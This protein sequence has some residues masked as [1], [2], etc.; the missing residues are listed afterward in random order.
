[1]P[2]SEPLHVPCPHCDALNR[3]P[4]ERLGQAPGCGRCHR[5][6][7]AAQPLA[8]DGARFEL[9]AGRGDIPLL[10]DFWAPWCGPCRT[11]APHFAAAAPQLEP[12]LRLAKVDTEAEPALGRRF[13]I[14]SIP[15][16]VLLRQGR[17]LARQAGSM[18]GAEIVRWAS[19][20]LP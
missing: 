1:M 18:S 15:T 13:A 5:P 12:R 8:L 11:M 9:H 19:A 6:L 16:L 10:V 7:F 3:V 20:H 2:V 14:R 17:E 4:P